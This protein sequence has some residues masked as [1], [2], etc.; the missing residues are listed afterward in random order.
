MT[1]ATTTET[2]RSPSTPTATSTSAAAPSLLPFQALPG[3]PSSSEAP[4][5]IPASVLVVTSDRLLT[6]KRRRS[7]R[8]APTGIE[9]T[10]SPS[11]TT[12]AVETHDLV[13]AR[14]VVQTPP[15]EAFS[16]ALDGQV[17]LYQVMKLIRR[18]RR[19]KSCCS[20]RPLPGCRRTPVRRH[21]TGGCYAGMPGTC[22][23]AR[24]SKPKGLPY[25]RP[26]FRV[27]MLLNGA[28]QRALARRTP[29]HP[30][31]SQWEGEEP[32]TPPARTCGAW[33]GRRARRN[34]A[35]QQI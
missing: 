33:Q 9:V 5:Q 28:V 20:A 11:T 22:V 27:S 14:K 30:I 15:L 26:F 31:P 1:N 2:S 18:P 7:N 21:P 10:G 8:P 17:V 34:H 12:T 16:P 35:P 13:A 29:T 6:Y 32:Y 24:G 23:A 4:S 25:G 3:R 19:R